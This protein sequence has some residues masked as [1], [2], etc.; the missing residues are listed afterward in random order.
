MLDYF[1]SLVP[2]HF[3]RLPLLKSFLNWKSVGN[4]SENFVELGNLEEIGRKRRI[5]GSIYVY[6][7]EADGLCWGL[8]GLAGVKMQEYVSR[9][10]EEF[11]RIVKEQAKSLIDIGEV[12]G[13][14]DDTFELVDSS[15]SVAYDS[16]K[17]V[18]VAENGRV[19]FR[20]FDDSFGVRLFRPQSDEDDVCRKVAGVDNIRLKVRDV[21]VEFTPFSRKV[22]DLVEELESRLRER[23]EESARGILCSC[24][25]SA[26][27]FCEYGGDEH[28]CKC[29]CMVG[30]KD[31]NGRKYT[32]VFYVNVRR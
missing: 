5:V 15:L 4:D 20:P 30:D 27:C 3:K 26:G 12:Y 25:K 11:A 17:G 23:V 2:R 31:A 7:P 32:R 9:S 8:Y 18:F 28:F 21:F 13:V 10:E 22:E 29:R 14:F 1:W 6:T 24:L 16:E 19:L